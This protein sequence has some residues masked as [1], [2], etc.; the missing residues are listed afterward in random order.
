MLQT[1]K[2]LLF[3]GSSWMPKHII[4]GIAVGEITRLL[5]Y[6][7]SPALYNYHKKRLLKSLKNR[8]Q[9]PKCILRQLHG[10]THSKRL[11]VLNRTWKTVHTEGHLSFKTMYNKCN[12]LLNSIFWKCWELL[13]DDRYMHLFNLFPNP[14]SNIYKNTKAMKAILS[15]K[16]R[17]FADKGR[18]ET[19]GTTWAKLFHFT[20]NLSVI[21]PYPIYVCLTVWPHIAHIP[22]GSNTQYNLP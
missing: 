20:L 16:R 14:P 22:P 21:R 1:N 19:L 7:E 8:Q 3:L 2:H 13:Y 15:A 4:R 12:H 10:M 6:T 9:H 17:K 18:Q 11:E 5:R